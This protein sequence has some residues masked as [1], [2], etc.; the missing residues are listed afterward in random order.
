M[1]IKIIAETVGEFKDN[2]LVD[3]YGVRSTAVVTSSISF[4]HSVDYSKPFFL[5]VAPYNNF[6]QPS[7]LGSPQ[8]TVAAYARMQTIGKTQWEGMGIA[9]GTVVTICAALPLTWEDRYAGKDSVVKV[10][11]GVS[12]TDSYIGVVGSATVVPRYIRLSGVK[13]V[14][15]TSGNNTTP[16]LIA[17][18][19]VS[20]ALTGVE[21]LL[22]A[23]NLNEGFTTSQSGTTTA[24]IPV[25]ENT[26]AVQVELTAVHKRTSPR[27]GTAKVAI[28]LGSM[29]SS[30]SPPLQLAN[31]NAQTKLSVTIDKKTH[32]AYDFSK[33]EHTLTLTP[34]A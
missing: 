11:G 16:D 15:I 4:K 14:V 22:S 27:A 30:I 7:N 33:F 28:T 5:Y 25:T 9:D 18:D 8:S 20:A 17:F 13:D 6:S 10:N 19:V 12:P 23:E 29:S 32:P 34:Q 26:E 31:Q 2:V 3:M 21:G 1:A 24:V